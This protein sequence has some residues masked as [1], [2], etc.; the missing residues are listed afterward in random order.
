MPQL[1]LNDVKVAMQSD[2][3]KMVIEEFAGR[4]YLLSNIPFEP[5]GNPIKGGPGWNISYVVKTDEA[6]TGF[7]DINGQ[8]TDTVAKRKVENVDLKIYGGSFTMDRALR[9][10]GGVEEE[11]EFQM[12]SL[13]QAAR[14]GFSYELINASKG[15]NAFDGLNVLLRGKST[16]VEAHATAYDLSTFENI[17][18]K[19]RE[20]A[21]IMNRWLST[22]DRTPDVLLVNP[23]MGAILKDVAREC[24]MYTQTMGEFGRTVEHFDGIPIQIIKGYKVEGQAEKDGIAISNDGNKVTDIYA[25]SFGGDGLTL[26]VPANISTLIDVIRPDF[27]EAKEQVRGLVELRA[28]PII[29]NTKSCGVLR[30]IKVK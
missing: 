27:N 6:K 12:R 18:T 26:G 5:I 2:L 20:F 30:K 10:Q 9:D 11:E 22:L 14:N 7:R 3:K 19:A 15:S 24:G 4:D 16:E 29:K 21:S 25:V 28:V 13:I 23:L 1:A 17:K 8:Y